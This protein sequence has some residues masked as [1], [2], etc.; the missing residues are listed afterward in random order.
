MSSSRLSDI[1]D[2]LYAK[3]YQ[4]LPLQTYYN[5]KFD[6]SA[7]GY[8]DVDNDTLRNDTIFLLNH[9]HQESAIIKYKGDKTPRKI[10]FDG[11]EKILEVSMYNTDSNNIS[12]LYKGL[13]FSFVEAKRYWIPKSK[14]DFKVGMIVEYFN[15]NQWS[16]KLVE[17][18]NQE[19]DKLYKLLIKYNKVRVESKK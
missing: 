8:S 6:D 18:P 14:D 1:T 4:V 3:D 16:E 7:M 13:S 15:N 12:Y 2:V 17:N 9:F 11:S 10:F 5:E 19:W